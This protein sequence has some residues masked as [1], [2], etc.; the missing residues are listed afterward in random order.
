VSTKTAPDL[1]AIWLVQEN[2]RDAVPLAI[3]SHDTLGAVFERRIRR[4]VANR[5]SHAPYQIA[6][7]SVRFEDVNGPRGGVDTV[8]RIKLMMIGRPPIV[9]EK[10]AT[11]HAPAFAS[12]VTALSTAIDRV[13]GKRRSTRA[14]RAR[15]GRR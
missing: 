6:R 9:V 11:S 13:G 14:P 5:V 8:C 12:A 3:R 10:R 1:H 7:A 15:A 4:Q 2:K